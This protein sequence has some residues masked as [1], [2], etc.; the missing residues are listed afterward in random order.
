MNKKRGIR[1]YVALLALLPLLT[2]MA[3]LEIFLLQDRFKDLDE[4]LTTRGQ[5]IAGQLA[6]SSEY[7]VF[8]NNL[9]FLEHIAK[10][11]AQQAD[12]EGVFILDASPAILASAGVPA[13]TSPAIQELLH[14]VNPQEPR[15][16]DGK[17][18]WLYQ[19]ILSTVVPLDDVSPSKHDVQQIGA[20]IIKM[21]WKRTHAMKLRLIGFTSLVTIASLL[22]ALFMARRVSRCITE[23]ISTLS[24]AIGRIGNGDLDSRVEADS[25]IA[26]LAILSNGINQ[27]TADLQH[28]RAILQHR[29]ELATEQLKN[30]AFFD[31]LT[32]LPNRRL[33]YDRLSHTLATS[34]RNGEFGALIFIDLDNFKPL[35]DKY[36]HAAGD[37]LL[38]ETASRIKHCLRKEDTVARFGGDE[39]VVMLCEL[40]SDRA[41][42]AAQAYK[43]AEK[44]RDQLAETYQ[45]SY[46][47]EE[48][49]DIRISHRCGASLGLVLFLGHGV[50]VDIIMNLADA[51]MYQAK[52][53]GKGQIH[54]DYENAVHI[55]A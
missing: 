23:P 21:S 5:M 27:M 1:T 25:R 22:L 29:I 6:G 35:N 26:E 30:L 17:A 14:R 10:N 7:G 18:L 55:P 36:G 40:G 11:A 8:S 9:M 12:V 48:Y 41:I 44:I 28:E 50:S 2:V 16:N 42:A 33:L 46:V 37:Q 31:T 32:M 49:E 19:P 53:R 39:F 52:K 20:V 47:Q 15:L 13:P 43:I 24:N 3:S 54:F 45:L 38:I 51:A 4:D 34:Q